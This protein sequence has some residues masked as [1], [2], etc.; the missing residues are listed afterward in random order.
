MSLV[1]RNTKGSPLTF[2]E[3]DGNLTYLESI[4][5]GQ[6]K[7]DPALDLF[8]VDF[9]EILPAVF[10]L[11]GAE[12]APGTTAPEY[13]PFALD[14][15]ILQPG[16]GFDTDA[17]VGGVDV[18]IENYSGE[19]YLLISISGLL[20]LPE[21]PWKD[22]IMYYYA[23]P[24]DLDSLPAQY[25][26]N[27]GV[28]LPDTDFSYRFRK[29]TGGSGTDVEYETHVYF[30]DQS[31]VIAVSVFIDYDGLGTYTSGELNTDGYN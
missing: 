5:G 24:E 1:L 23:G 17:V 22:S 25:E 7:P 12:P 3:M 9:G 4:A 27:F 8:V 6:V 18:A 28:K 14:T 19:D 11:L 10:D 26:R 21:S 15:Y 31:T 20:A 2:N 30:K 16:S 13:A 29:Y